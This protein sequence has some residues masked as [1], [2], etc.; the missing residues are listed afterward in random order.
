MTRAYNVVE[1]N[2]FNAGLITDASPLT[3]P[4]NSSLEED[5]FVLNVDGSRN[6]RLGMDYETGYVEINTSVPYVASV[7]TG[8]R[9]FRWD[10]AGG[11]PSRSIEV[12]QIGN[13][14][15]FFELTS[16]PVS[17]GYFHTEYFPTAPLDVKFSFSVVDGLLI[18][19]NGDKEIY[20]FEY[21]DPNTITRTEKRLLIRDLFGVDDIIN[22]IDITR[23]SE[24]QDRPTFYDPR[25]VY[26]LRNQSFGIPRINGNNESV[27][28]PISAFRSASGSRFPSNSDSVISALYPDA[29][30]TDNRV[31]DRFFADDLY[32]NPL[33]TTRA[34]QGYFI[35]DVLDRGT[36]RTAEIT[37][38]TARYP[39]LS[40]SALPLPLD[41]SVNGASTITE[42]AGRIFY[43]GFSGEVIDGDSH[44]PK[45][46]SYVLFSKVV[47]STADITSCY[48][49]GDPTS[50]E[51]PDILATDGG[52]IRINEAYGIHKLLNLGGSLM[53]VATNGVWRIVGGT[54]NG[55]TANNYI[56]EKIT[57]RGCTSP[58]S[59]TVVDNGFMYWGDDAIYY[60]SPDQLGSW[61]GNNISFGRIQKYYDAINIGD[62]QK[63]YGAYDS[64]ERKVRWLYYNS[65]NSIL[66]TRELILDLQLQAFYTNTISKLS[67]DF[68]K[69]VAMY[70]GLSY[71]VDITESA[72]VA[73]GDLVVVNGDPVVISSED[74]L[75]IGQ[76]E[77][78]YVVITS[79]D[80][81]IAYTFS[82]YTNT[83]F[84]DWYSEDEIGVDAPAFLVT[85]Y[86][87]GTDF[88][89]DKQLPYITIHMRRT[90]NGFDDSLNPINQSSCLVQARWDWSNSDKSGKWGRE[91]Q[92][93]RYRRLYI[94]LNN[95][96]D[97]DNGFETIVTRNKLRGN[98]KVLSLK[99]RTEPYR[100]LHLYGW[101][102]IF[103]VAENV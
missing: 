17:Q 65:S 3:T 96:D 70:T 98:G 22:G 89:R 102:M 53:I 35:I 8:I 14:L 11:E 90:E 50:K 78:G 94:P 33:G 29:E 100:N 25:H 85:S 91:F 93:Y 30:D 84:R 77:L 83:D 56:V 66:P 18:A 10:N 15:D 79:I 1:V 60:V 74:K 43:A 28:D 39:Q 95:F 41:E 58:N 103:S 52:F 47:D 67:T 48:Q 24:V 40:W 69:V 71:E 80:N 73:D 34:A 61:V 57:D 82:K 72:I 5:N 88:Q 4:D 12:V 87:S 51:F 31:V 7:V 99:F 76:R 97:Y 26:N 13:T 44:S 9:T 6:R 38:N 54:D 20:I 81:N 21:S 101:S 75:G 46:S 49:S 37:K 63:A 64:Y 68:P 23:G 16:L 45:L 59:I 19:V 36:S 32:K 55:F 27:I 2:K 42:F 92:A 62:K 86:M